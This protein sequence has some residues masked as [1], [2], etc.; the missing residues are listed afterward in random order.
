MWLESVARKK[1]AMSSPIET[2]NLDKT[3]SWRP[4]LHTE[5]YVVIPNVL[6]QS[7]VDQALSFTWDWLESLGSGISKSDPSTWQDKNWP[8]DLKSGIVTTC[9]A[10]QQ[11][12][13]WFV[14]G[15][16]RVQQA[17]S[18]VWGEEQLITSMDCV[19][20]WRPWLVEGAEGWRPVT[21]GLHI[22]QNP[23]NKSGLQCV[24]GMVPLC[25]VTKD[26]GG[27]QVVPRSHKEYV[28]DII[29]RDHPEHKHSGDFCKVNPD[30]YKGAEALLEA[31]AGDLILW[32]SRLIHGGTVGSAS[33]SKDEKESDE[34]LARCAVTVCMVPQDWASQEVRDRR[35]QAWETG[36][37][38]THWPHEF[39]PHDFT[40]TDGKNIH[41]SYKQVELSQEQRELL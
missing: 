9:R 18:A 4:K 30:N 40:N 24:Q 36:Q 21:E 20:M 28:Q 3:D 11:A 5:G 39:Y 7:E 14:R 17:F 35:R 8:G 33:I 12:A 41:W 34:N 37:G 32:D 27:L 13:A 22:D 10:A 26:I 31:N 25:K 1:P 23:F 2:I 15:S 16:S 29:R 38:L 19:I 6:S